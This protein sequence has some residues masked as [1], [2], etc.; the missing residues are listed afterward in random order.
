MAVEENRR[1]RVEEAHEGQAGGELVDDEGA[2]LE[3]LEFAGEGDLDEE[4]E[5]AQDGAEDGEAVED[6]HG[7][8]PSAAD[9][10]IECACRIFCE[11][12]SLRRRV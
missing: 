10:D 5:V 4:L 9:T 7:D 1:V 6:G 8:G 12:I 3:G 11:L 2:G